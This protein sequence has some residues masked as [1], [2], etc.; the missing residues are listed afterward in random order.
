MVTIIILELY[1]IHMLIRQD[2]RLIEYPLPYI[3]FCWRC[4]IRAIFK[5]MLAN[6]C[7]AYRATRYRAA[8]GPPIIY[9]PTLEL[10]VSA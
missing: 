10:A 3:V 8:I 4:G 2:L 1:V 9:S 6:I 7:W 5:P